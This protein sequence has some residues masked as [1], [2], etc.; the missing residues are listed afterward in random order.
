MNNGDVRLIKGEW[1]S[2]IFLILI[3]MGVTIWWSSAINTR[4]DQLEVQANKGSRFTA[5]DGMRLGLAFD[6]E[7]R[8]QRELLES[9]IMRTE[10][11]IAEIH[12]YVVEDKI[13]LQFHGLP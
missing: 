1:L 7:Q 5:S 9:H 11:M 13:R 6:V 12:D 8:A 10:P 3:Q 4:V 2:V